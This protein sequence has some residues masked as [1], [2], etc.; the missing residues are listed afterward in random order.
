MLQFL[1]NKT[2]R[3]YMNN[4][5]INN[6]PGRAPKNSSCQAVGEG[7]RWTAD[8]CAHLYFS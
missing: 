7:L 1:R 4:R 3:T 6:P 5:L 8:T 2:L